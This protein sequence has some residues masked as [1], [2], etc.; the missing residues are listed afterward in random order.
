MT[1]WPKA[2]IEAHREDLRQRRDAAL[3]ARAA[4]DRILGT[5]PAP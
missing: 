4:A 2:R 5:P 3:K 1:D